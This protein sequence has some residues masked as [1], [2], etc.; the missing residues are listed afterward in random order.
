MDL[1]FRDEK[2]AATGCLF[3]RI[4]LFNLDSGDFIVVDGHSKQVKRVN[5]VIYEKDLLGLSSSAEILIS[6]ATPEPNI[7]FWDPVTGI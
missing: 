2:Y 4:V 7:R 6:S 5:C 3:G 1:S